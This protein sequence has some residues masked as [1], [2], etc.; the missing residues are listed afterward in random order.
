MSNPLGVSKGDPGRGRGGAGRFSR[1]SSPC[2]S[3][4]SRR[5]SMLLFFF[6]LSF[7]PTPAAC[8]SSQSRGRM[9]VAP[10]SLHHSHSNNL[11]T[12][13]LTATLDL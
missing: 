11:H 5:R 10:G 2:G 4:N 13:H 3:L 8:G 6:F 1:K 7:R 9:G 12:P